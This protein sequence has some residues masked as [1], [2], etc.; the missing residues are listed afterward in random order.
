MKKKYDQHKIERTKVRQQQKE[1]GV[2]DGRFNSRVEKPK[3]IYN[4]KK[5][6]KDGDES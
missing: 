4:R 1:Q 3:N 2:F 6:H 5:K